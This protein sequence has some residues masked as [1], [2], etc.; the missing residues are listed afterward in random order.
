MKRNIIFMALS[1]VLLLAFACQKEDTYVPGKPTV[2]ND[3]VYFSPDNG[4]SAVLAVD[5]TEVTVLLSRMDSTDALTVPVTAWTSHP[6]AFELP[7][8]VEFAAGAATAEYKI[9]TTDSLDMFVNYPIRLSIPEEL[10][11]AY[12]TLDVY[13]RFAL[14]VVKEDYKPYANGVWV[15]YFMYAADEPAQWEQILEYSEILDLYRF[16]DVWYPGYGVQF[17]WDGAGNP[18]LAAS[19]TTG[20]EDSTYGMITANTVDATYSENVFVLT[21]EWTVSA[22]SFGVAPQIYTITEKL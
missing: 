8:K 12:D 17:S 20:V 15:D 1:A 5:E 13:P 6:A 14:N 2:E 4:T 16:S 18:V 7:E 22:G 11:N 3:N 10:T 21:F 19:Y 9:K